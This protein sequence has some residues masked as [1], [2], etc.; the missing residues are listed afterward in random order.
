MCLGKPGK[1]LEVLSF[2]LNIDF[3]N[4]C[5]GPVKNSYV[6]TRRNEQNDA[7]E[8]LISFNTR[9]EPTLICLLII[10]IYSIIYHSPYPCD[11]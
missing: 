11:S 6:H 3:E 5:V 7:F 2:V 10:K 8:F 9:I 1:V 4:V